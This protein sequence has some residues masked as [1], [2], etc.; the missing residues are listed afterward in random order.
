MHYSEHHHPSISLAQTVVSPGHCSE[1]IFR[2]R[3]GKCIHPLNYT[4]GETTGLKCS[5]GPKEDRNE[6]HIQYTTK[7]HVSCHELPD[8]VQ[9]D[10]MKSI[11]QP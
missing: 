4:T 8:L 10:L 6:L 5:F 3:K 1:P 9:L 7:Y 11:L 2:E